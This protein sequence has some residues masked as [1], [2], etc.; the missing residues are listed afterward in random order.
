MYSRNRSFSPEDTYRNN[1]PPV[2]SGSRFRYRRQEDGPGVLVNDARGGERKSGGGRDV[3]PSDAPHP[4]LLPDSPPH[5][6]R[7]QTPMLLLPS[8]LPEDSGQIREASDAPASDTGEEAKSHSRLSGWGKSLSE[9]LHGVAGS[10]G[11]EDLLLLSL[12][13][14]LS[15]EHERSMD[16]IV[17]LLLLMGMK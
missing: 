3:S 13:L 17:I 11:Q 8:D 10:I 1:L 2:Y 6:E 9:L 12:L 14:L 5:S 7:E 15:A 4:D 16:V